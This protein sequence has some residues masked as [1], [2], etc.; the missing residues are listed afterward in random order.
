MNENGH[1]R[2]RADA[3]TVLGAALDVQ[4]VEFRELRTDE[5][6]LEAFRSAI[7]ADLGALDADDV[8]EALGKYLDS[9][10]HVREPQ[11]GRKALAHER[12]TGR[13]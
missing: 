11:R 7:A 13:Q 2:L 10:I 6:Y 3:A 9:R 4:S 5:T 8:D 12:A 1:E